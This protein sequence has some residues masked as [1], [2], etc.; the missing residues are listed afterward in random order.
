LRKLAALAAGAALVH[1][2]AAAS[3]ERPEDAAALRTAALQQE[4]MVAAFLCND[5]AAYNEFVLSHRPALQESDR[6]LMAVFE[7]A[8]PETAF[9]AY[10]LYKTELANASSLRRARDPYFCARADANFRAA[11]GRTLEETLAQ[12]PYPVETGSV[13]CPW[14]AIT[15][16]APPP[17]APKRIRHRTWLGRL[18][19]AVL[20]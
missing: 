8:G 15:S 5:V 16:A 4:M 12:I 2:A 1:S 3:C 14:T 18:V 13:R 6:N 7:R 20:R 10:N 11:S 19:D 17:A 9:D